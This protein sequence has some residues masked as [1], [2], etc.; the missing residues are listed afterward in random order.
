MTMKIRY[1][2]LELMPTPKMVEQVHAEWKAENPTLKMMDHDE[3]VT[4]VYDKIRARI[5]I[6]GV[7]PHRLR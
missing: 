3:F 7:T 2:N 6:N 5:R 1:G 4:R